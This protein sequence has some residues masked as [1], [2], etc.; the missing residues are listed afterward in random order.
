MAVTVRHGP[1][2]R[3]PGAGVEQVVVQRRR[4]G[5]SGV[6][7]WSRSPGPRR[8]GRPAP[9]PGPPGCSVTA[10]CHGRPSG[11]TTRT[12]PPTLTTRGAQALLLAR[13]RDRGRRPR[14]SRSRRGRGRCRA[15]SAAGRRR[16]RDLAA[17]RRRAG[18]APARVA[19]CVGAL[20][21][22]REV[23]VVAELDQRP[24][25]QRAHQA[26]RSAAA[27]SSATSTAATQQRVDLDP[28]ARVPVDPGEVGVVAEAAAGLV[29][30]GQHRAAPAAGPGRGRRAGV[31]PGRPRCR[32]PRSTV[33][34]SRIV[35]TR[36][37]APEP[38]PVP[39]AAVAG[40]GRRG[41]QVPRGPRHRPRTTAPGSRRRSHRWWCWRWTTRPR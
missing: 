29:D 32:A 41:R 23:A 6:P 31:R 9:R 21:E 33:M 34:S 3:Q 19:G 26:L 18:S 11:A 22:Q 36:S 14:P 40:Q 39:V 15:G 20:D 10:T 2:R 7:G 27:A 8:R 13:G 25:E 4:R 37:R 16:S 35:R 1:L 28:A 38:E 5:P 30:V 24:S 12:S 17:T